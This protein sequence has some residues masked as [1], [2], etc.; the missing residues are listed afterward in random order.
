M[1]GNGYG[2]RAISP[3]L[4]VVGEFLKALGAIEINCEA[5]KTPNYF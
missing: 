2:I 5:N 3:E 4:L 1:E